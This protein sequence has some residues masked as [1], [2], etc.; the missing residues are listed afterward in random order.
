VL[1]IYFITGNDE[2]L[3]E[4][5]EVQRRFGQ[6]FAITGQRYEDLPE[7]LGTTEKE[8]IERKALAAFSRFRARV[9]VDHASL[10]IHRLGNLPGRASKPFWSAVGPELHNILARLAVDNNDQSVYEASV[11]V[12]VAYC[13]PVRLI[14]SFHVI[15]GKIVPPSGGRFDWDQC[16]SP[17]GA[18]HNQSYADMDLTTK[19]RF[20][21]RSKAFEDLFNRLA[22]ISDLWR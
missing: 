15:K 19:Y 21:A 5:E 12:D 3:R 11:R 22:T 20:S 8:L 16:F 17:E 10:F 2:K 14:P 18:P 9:L 4:F 1:T 13:D 7:I 6:R